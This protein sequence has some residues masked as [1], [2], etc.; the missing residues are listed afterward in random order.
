MELTSLLLL[1]LLGGVASLG[2]AIALFER[3]HPLDVIPTD[4]SGWP[5]WI[6]RLGVP[7]ALL[8]VLGF[9]VVKLAKWAGPKADALIDGVTT[10]ANALGPLLE[11]Q[12]A[13]DQERALQERAILV[14]IQALTSVVGQLG[15]RLAGHASDV[16]GMAENLA[17]SS[18]ST[19]RLY[20]DVAKLSDEVR[21]LADLKK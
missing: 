15:D 21:R 10:R 12:A 14:S 11:A 18:G 20:H 8:V 4:P 1:W 19:E 17:R 6:E 3:S 9:A 13:R 7:V 5:T 2:V 16:H